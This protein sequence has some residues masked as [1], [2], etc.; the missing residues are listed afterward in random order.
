[1]GGGVRQVGSEPVVKQQGGVSRLLQGKK[2]CGVGLGRL[3]VESLGGTIVW[4]F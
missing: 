3:W 2:Q 4:I 1:M